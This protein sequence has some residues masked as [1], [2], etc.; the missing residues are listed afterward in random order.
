[1]MKQLKQICLSMLLLACSVIAFAESPKR[2]FRATW[3]AAV[4]VDWPDKKVTTTGSSTQITAQ[5]NELIAYLDQLVASK[6]NAIFYHVRPMADAFYKSTYEPWS[7]Y[8]T[9]TRGKD[10]GYDPLEFAVAEAHKRGLEIHAWVNPFRH[11]ASGLSSISG[12]S[13]DPIKNNHSDWLLTYSSNSY[14]GTWLDPGNPEVRAH[15]VKV[16]EEIVNNYDIDG[17]V[18]DD[19]FYPYGGTT[20]QDA[21]SKSKYKPSGQS[22]GDWRR[23]NIDAAIKAVYDMIA[24]SKRPWVRFGVSPFGIYSNATAPHTKYGVTKPSGITGMDAY[25]E[26][27]CNTLEWMKGGYVDYVSPQL[28]WASN[29]SG[30]QYGVLAQWW[31]NMAKTFSDKQ[32]GGKKIHFFASQDAGAH[33]TSEIGT[34]IDYNRSYTTQDA[35]G[36]IFFSYDDIIAKSLPSYL[37]SNKFTQLAL[38]PAMDWKTSATLAAPTGV[39]LSGTTLSWSHSTADRFTVYAYTKGT[40][41][42]TAMASS[43]NLVAVVYGKSL[44]VSSVSSYSSK[45]FAVRAYD[46]YGNEHNAGFYN[47][48]VQE[49]IITTNPTSFTLTGKVG[50]TVI[51]D[52]DVAAQNLTSNMTFASSASS[53]VSVASL[54][55]WDAKTGGTLRVTLNTSAAKS[56]TTGYVAIQSGTARKEVTFTATVQALTPAISVSSSSVSLTGKIN[57]TSAPYKDVT[58]TA[59]DL[60]ADLSVTS[61]DLVTVTKLSGWNA[62][63]GGTLRLTLNTSKSVGTHSGSVTITSSGVTKTISVSGTITALLPSI[64]PSPTS[65]LLEGEEG[66]SGVYQDVTISGVDLSSSMTI[67]TSGDAFTY[68]TPSWNAT[69]G[70]T[71][72]LTLNTAKAVGTYSGSVTIS[73]GT[74]QTV[75]S[76]TSIVNEAYVG[77]IIKAT[78]SEVTLTAVKGAAKPTAN[79]TVTAS[80]LTQKIRISGAEEDEEEEEEESSSSSGGAITYTKSSWNNRT[81]GTLTISASTA[82]IGTFTKTITLTSK[83]AQSAVITVTVVITDPNAPVTPSIEATPNPIT[84]SCTLNETPAPYVDVTVK[85]TGLTSAMSVARLISAVNFEKLSDWNDLTGGTLRISANSTYV[86]GAGTYTSYVALQSGTTREEIDFTVTITDPNAGSGDTGSEEPTTGTVVFDSNPIWSKPV[87]EATYLSNGNNN[88][89]MAY[90]NGEL[91]IADVASTGYHVVN[92]GTGSF[93]K[94]VSTG[95]GTF[96]AHNLRITSDGQMLL[97]NTESGSSSMVLKSWDRVSSLGALGTA[98]INGRCDYFYPYGAWN[99]S[100]YLVALS[101][102]GYAVK[103]PYNAG[104]LSTAVNINSTALATAGTSAKAIPAD[105]NSFYASAKDK[106]PVKYSLSNGAVLEQFGSEQPVEKAG[107]SGLGVFT[108]HNKTFMVTPTDSLGG[109]EIFDI[110][111]GL[112]SATRVA[113]QVGKMGTNANATMTIDFCTWVNGDNAYIYQLVPNN[114]IRAFLLTYKLDASTTGLDAV[115]QDVL[116][117]P[118]S[119]GVR[120]SFA[121]SKMV[122][123]YSVNGT[124]LYQSLQNDNVEM[125]LDKGLYII[126]VGD[127]VHKF[128]R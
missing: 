47:S 57:A 65:V 23:A 97:G 52:I 41:A 110:T 55:G 25:D 92:A 33:A 119:E 76:V 46:R 14:S 35:P 13:S 68:S 49:P 11:M 50:S 74:A 75:I 22:D 77:P 7:H 36:S 51:C 1:M 108:V 104:A 43:S 125:A 109:F 122:S 79:I 12:A 53:L 111:D 94:T 29:K 83:N 39:K 85:A 17:I 107:A 30:Q 62:R 67:K 127:R 19:Y 24:A 96:G 124:L 113:G 38:P 128:I 102:T 103:I 93:V 72:R 27:Y 32:T 20:T 78:P 31:S 21:T 9:G 95:Y 126:K 84:L 48:A 16:I 90:Y 121:G 69:T 64:T 120:I 63:T 59:S 26:I 106:L 2:E 3:L 91:Y 5:K 8:L 80:N 115:S 37:K 44:D 6:Q 112:G 87:T 82:T 88:R 10:P 101:N 58:V 118:T 98:A 99:G 45:T 18:F 86:S 105:A 114:G 70:G 66:E 60:T 40:D 4:G 71:L 73:S 15:V 123:I 89:S 100:G 28:Y 56:A 42:G 54:S 81:G 116:I 117:S 61:T 34:Q